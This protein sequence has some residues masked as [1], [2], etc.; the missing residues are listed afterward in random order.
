[1]KVIKLSY[2]DQPELIRRVLKQLLGPRT[3]YQIEGE[4]E[5]MLTLWTTADGLILGFRP[6]PARK[7]DPRIDLPENGRPLEEISI[8][9]DELLQEIVGRSR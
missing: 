4:P 1:M 3:R 6:E 5:E 2:R 7:L 8:Y 9:I